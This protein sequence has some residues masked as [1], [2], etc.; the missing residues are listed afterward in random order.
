MTKSVLGTEHPGTPK[1][2]W[3][4]V[5]NYQSRPVFADIQL[6]DKFST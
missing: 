4:G 1:E 6:P 2:L 3:L 5:K